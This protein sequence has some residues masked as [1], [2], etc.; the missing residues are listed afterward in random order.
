MANPEH[1]EILA[2]GVPAWN[3]WRAENRGINPDLPGADL[4]GAH[5]V[6]VNLSGANLS[7]G[8]L[9][10]AELINANLNSANLTAV[11]LQVAELT[12][13][14]LSSAHLTAADLSR[15][16]LINANLSRA[17]LSRAS[18]MRTL[19]RRTI[20]AHAQ[21][22][23]ARMGDVVIADVDL[24]EAI[25]LDGVIHRSPST[26]GIDTIYRSQ[27]KISDAFLRGAGVP[28]NLIAYMRSL[29]G[30]AFDFYACFIS[31]AAD[32]HDFALRL[33]ADLQAREVRCWHAPEDARTSER[34]RSNVEESIR[35]HEK[36]LLVLSRNSV[37]SAWVA[38]EVEAAL[39]R[40]RREKRK[41]LFPVR[42]D[43]EVM[44]TDEA[45]AAEIRRTRQIA[46]MSGWKDHDAYAIAF[47][48]LLR[49]LAAG[50]PA[51]ARVEPEPAVEPAEVGY[52]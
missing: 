36:L 27:G 41:V 46:D 6:G 20:L 33:H 7:Y 43:D 13:A 52:W 31:Y 25:G 12:G 10:R 14:D 38:K 39:E 50:E 3:A 45:L 51:D 22:S 8:N 48:R 42:L 5:L 11:D 21:L 24:S 17:T 32:D 9:S 28:E 16:Y 40:E 29:A 1:L 47:E 35:I 44:E 34:F 37:R 26:I 2:S 23:R 49:D 18:L 15:A 4:S 19:F 30:A